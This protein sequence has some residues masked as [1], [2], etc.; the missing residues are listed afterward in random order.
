MESECCGAEEWYETGLCSE[1]KE[2]T[3]F[4][5]EKEYPF[6]EGDDYYTI[7]DDLVIWFCWDHVSEEIHND[8]PNKKYFSNSKDAKEYLNK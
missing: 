5:E 1:C 3:E 6:K 2:H 4:T 7:E 8:T